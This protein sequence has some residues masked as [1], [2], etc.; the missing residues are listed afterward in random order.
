MSP[1]DVLTNKPAYLDQ[2]SQDGAIY[3]KL[4]VIAYN[5]APAPHPET[6]FFY[7]NQNNGNCGGDSWNLHIDLSKSSYYKWNIVDPNV[8]SIPA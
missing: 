7:Q 8:V 5:D 6:W 2:S 3:I 1:A 4:N